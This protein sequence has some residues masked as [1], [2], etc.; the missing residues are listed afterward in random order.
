MVICGIV[1]TLTGFVLAK[2]SNR[3]HSLGARLLARELNILN[4]GSDHKGIG[5][6]VR[7]KSYYRF[8]AFDFSG[9]MY[10]SNH[11][12]YTLE[13]IEGDCEE[14]K[15]LAETAKR[16]IRKEAEIAHK[17]ILQDE[18]KKI[19]SLDIPEE[20]KTILLNNLYEREN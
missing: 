9:I 1:D 19:N 3:R 17:K 16:A 7:G 15:Q 18:E 5:G 6:L 20:Y 10:F 4:A 11:Y 13:R 12:S 14:F 2:S 8:H